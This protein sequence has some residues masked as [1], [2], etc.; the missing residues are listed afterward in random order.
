MAITLRDL[1]GLEGPNLYYGQPCVKFELWA[2]R[3]IRR[4]IADTIKTWAQSIGI[5]I[6]ALQQDVVPSEGGFVITTTFLTPFPTVGEKMCEGV[7][8]DLQAAEA[9]DEE[10]SHDELVWEVMGERKREEPSMKVLQLHAEARAHGLPVLL[11]D[12]GKLMIGTGKRGF[13]FDPALIGLGIEPEVP[14][15]TLGRIPL[16]AVTGTNGKTTTVRLISHI[17]A[18]T[19]LLVGRTD[20]D[21]VYIGAEQVEEG[22]WAGFGGAR[23]VMTDPQVDVAVLETS[24]GGILRRGLAF[25][26]SDVS[27][28]TNVSDDHLHELGVETREEMARVKGVITLVVEPEGY[29]VLNADDPLVWELR[30][31]MVGQV[32][33]F[34]RR[35]QDSVIQEHQATGG[36]VVASDGEDVV[37]DV[38]VVHARL[39]L[40]DIPLTVGGA[41]LHNVENVLAATAASIALGISSDEIKAALLTFGTQPEQ[42][43]GRL[44]LFRKGDQVVVLDYAHN[45]ASLTALLA[46]GE[47]LRREGGSRLI[48]IGG[49]PGDRPDEQIRKQGMLAGQSGDLL[50]LHEEERY[51]RG[52]QLGQIPELYRSGAIAGGMR[53]ELISMFPDELTALRAALQQARQGDVI[54]AA[55]HARRAEMLAALQ[56][57]QASEAASGTT[58]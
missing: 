16:V 40:R 29:I 53:P 34:T 42:N 26:K 12:D 39:P 51:L 32:I 30:E 18:S 24:R 11:R 15:E 13:I 9:G 52:R 35:P 33:A 44:N 2:D 31:Y 7:L 4:S 21:G 17:L 48:I 3:D 43:P 8:G 41:A 55:A 54:L 37:I 56:A 19:G 58:A 46:L 27:V 20:T 47:R 22:D 28:I 10:Y 25:S 57:W 23:R 36:G 38:G 5:V 49:G 1:R 14:W 50:F 6:G 45:E